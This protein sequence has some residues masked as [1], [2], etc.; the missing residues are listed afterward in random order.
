LGGLHRMMGWDGPMLT[1]SGG[2]QIF[3][4]GSGASAWEIKGK[5]RLGRNQSLVKIDENGALFR[6]HVD[7]SYRLLT[8]EKS[9]QIQRAL[10]A[11]IILTLDECT[12]DHAQESYMTLSTERSHR[13]ERRSLEEFLRTD[14]GTQALYGIIQGA[15]YEHL[16]RESCDF[17][18]SGAFFGQAVGGSLGVSE[19]QMRR[20]IAMVGQMK[21]PTLPTHLLGIG[22]VG[23]ILW[24]VQWGMD[25][26][27]CVHPTRLA[28]H[29]GALV[30][31]NRGEGNF[32]INLKNARFRQDGGPIDG[33]C[34]CYACRR[35]S[36]A[37]IHHL[38]KAGEQLGGQLLTI[39][40]MAFM[41]R[42]MERIRS[43]IREQN[44]HGLVGELLP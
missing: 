26:F 41:C 8:P 42:L 6:S 2:Y 5:R 22:T 36:C 21:N 4:L 44:F 1:D 38:L 29:G 20:V 24:G 39:H 16:R 23:A 9:I 30:F 32:H 15:T 27:D 43:A 25:T 12:P 31:K 17:V 34:P 40:N 3:S 10:G 18:G 7:G 28:R 37:Y 14:D 33:E 13:W 11:D 35:A 19:E